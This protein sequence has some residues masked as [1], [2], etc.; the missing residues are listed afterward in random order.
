[1]FQVDRNF[2]RTLINPLQQLNMQET[3]STTLPK[4]QPRGQW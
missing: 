2:E 3:T 1:M 4:T